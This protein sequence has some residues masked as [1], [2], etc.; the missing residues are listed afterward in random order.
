[1]QERFLA[2]TLGACADYVCLNGLDTGLGGGDLC[3]R[4]IDTGQRSLNLGVL[5]LALSSIVF[6]CSFGSLNGSDGL[7]HLC[8]EIV[9]VQLDNQFPLAHLLVI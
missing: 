8:P 3:L 4:L 9:I 7:I 2:S 6:D 5:K 1:L